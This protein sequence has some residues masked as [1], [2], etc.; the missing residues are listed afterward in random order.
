MSG[1]KRPVPLGTFAEVSTD[2]PYPSPA[3]AGTMSTMRKLFTT[4]GALVALVLV[5][6]MVAA[7]E[8]FS[9]PEDNGLPGFLED[10]VDLPP[11]LAD[12]DALP[13][14]LA[15][16]V[17]DGVAPGQAKQAGGWIP[18]G[19]AMK[20][21]DWMPPGLAEQEKVPPGHARKL[22]IEPTPGDDTDE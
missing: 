20:G 9:A 14:G 3:W 6:G 2:W 15:K 11:G 4:L 5:A 7:Q 16:K 10:E 17:G 21:D 18:P 8:G 22:G 19:Q 12:R 1:T 13:P